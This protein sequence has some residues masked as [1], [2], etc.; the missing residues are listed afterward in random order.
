MVT[1][2]VTGSLLLYRSERSRSNP[3]HHGGLSHF[4]AA[5][6]LGS[7]ID[8]DDIEEIDSGSDDEGGASE[9]ASRVSQLQVRICAHG[10]VPVN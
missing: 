3:P 6:S 1:I 9:E 2:E 7:P 10:A 5:R 8:P 4:H